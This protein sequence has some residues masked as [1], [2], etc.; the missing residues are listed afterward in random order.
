MG[1]FAFGFPLKPKP[2]PGTL[3]KKMA[4]W[5]KA[6]TGGALQDLGAEPLGPGQLVQVPA[7][8]PRE[9]IHE[10]L[11][12]TMHIHIIACSCT[13]AYTLQGSVCPQDL[14]ITFS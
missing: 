9:T 8:N 3:N 5:A 14:K 6:I 12:I 4:M 1:A 13:C 11:H 7:K 10:A 2:H